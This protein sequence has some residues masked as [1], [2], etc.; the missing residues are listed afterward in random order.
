MKPRVDY[1]LYLC[2]D[3]ELM[4]EDT[5][6]KS[7]ELAIQGG[8]SV[9]QLREKDCS[10][11]EFLQVAREVKQITDAY[12]IPL[13]INDRIDIAMA[14]DADG[15]HL[16]Q[17]DIPAHTAREL[18]GPDKIIGVSAYNKELAVEAQK[19]GADYLGVGDIFGTSTKAGT[20]HVEIDTLRRICQAVKIPVV[21]IG[22]INLSNVTKLAGTGIQ[23]TAVISA[24]IASKNIT[25][26][27]T[28]MLSLLK[29]E[30]IVNSPKA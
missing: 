13:I 7:V 22:G 4:S 14:V 24:I 10:G 6:E 5:L 3:R 27:A 18:L 16:G 25:E 12:E 26:A 20:H 1:T 8:V 2:T 21:A 19:E 29:N 30:V 17:S 11:R 28:K 15:V 9:V 23:G